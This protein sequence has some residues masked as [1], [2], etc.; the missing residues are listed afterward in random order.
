MMVGYLLTGHLSQW[1]EM[2]LNNQRQQLRLLC[3]PLSSRPGLWQT[4]ELL[5][6]P[7]VFVLT[8][9]CVRE[10]MVTKQPLH[11]QCLLLFF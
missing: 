9:M 3:E 5:F 11:S 6:V 7:R 8:P 1:M 4:A 10:G 2:A